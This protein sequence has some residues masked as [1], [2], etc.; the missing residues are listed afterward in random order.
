M[1]T[2]SGTWSTDIENILENTRKNCIYL[3]KLHK[4]EYLYYKSYLK[5]FK[6]PIIMISAVNSVVSIGLQPYLEQNYIS[7][8]NCSLS[9]ICGIIGSIEMYLGINTCCENELDMSKSFYLLS[10]DIFKILTLDR[11]NRTV[12]GN[13]FL[14]STLNSYCKL[15]EQ[16]N[17]TAKRIED[18]LQ[19]IMHETTNK[20]TG[21]ISSLLESEESV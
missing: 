9:L 17:I 6:L 11:D 15:I 2:E 13:A 14:E 20:L 16:S 4:K 1:I 21:S 7:V 19:P 3:S 18:Q 12:D 10:I 8:L 5:W